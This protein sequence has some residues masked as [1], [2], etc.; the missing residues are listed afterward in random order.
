[1]GNSD[2]DSIA[3]IMLLWKPLNTTQSCEEGDVPA[4]PYLP[5]V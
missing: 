2:G 3:L 1:M 4:T 5:G